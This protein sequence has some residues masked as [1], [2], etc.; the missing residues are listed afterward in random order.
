M[1]SVLLA[2]MAKHLVSRPNLKQASVQLVLGSATPTHDPKEGSAA[3]LDL[4]PPEGAWQ[5]VIQGFPP[6]CAPS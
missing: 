6:K 2:D 5:D 4:F 1:I 3:K